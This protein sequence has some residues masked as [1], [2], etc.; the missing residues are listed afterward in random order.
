MN[1]V[2]PTGFTYRQFCDEVRRFDQVQ[3]LT[4]IARI[5]ITLPED[6]GDQRYQR[7]PPWTL[8]ALAK[9]SICHGNAYRSTQVL[10][11]DIARLCWMY[12]NINPDELGDPALNPL[13]NSLL[14]IAYEQFPYQESA[15]EELA[16]VEA[17]FAGYSGRKRLEVL[18]EAGVTELLGAPTGPAVGVAMMLH[19]S[20]MI[21]N[22]FF[23]PAWLDQKNFADVLSIL[24]REHIESV[25][26]ESFA[27]DI[28]GFRRLAESAPPLANLERY[29]FN[30]LTARPF[31]RLADGRLIAPV[32]QLIARRLSPIELYYPGIQRWNQPF[33]R[34][35]G[36]L[37]EDYVGRQLRTLPGATVYSEIK[38]GPKKE[39]KDSIDWIA[40][41]PGLVLLVEAKASRLVAA[42]R[43]GGKNAQQAV[44][45]TLNEA[46]I[47]IERTYQ[48]INDGAAGFSE[49][50]T[51]RPFVGLVATLDSAY[52]AN[53]PLARDF[54]YQARLPTL[55][56][57]VRELE[58]LVAV[59]QRLPASEVL[60]QIT[61]DPEMRTS[62]LGSALQ[63]FQDDKYDNPILDAAFDSYPFSDPTRADNTAT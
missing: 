27:T 18:D 45:E 44:A 36:E 1:T 50:P 39:K 29:M 35:L 9:A 8:A 58:S 7:T 55:I 34:D 5:A 26:N 61:D 40:V 48:A 42:A 3:M 56:G 43:A 38:Y 10:P 17:F 16:R 28:A 57:S 63:R 62:M 21:N 4:G 14:R 46:L 30:P 54:L 49:I 2:E 22:G 37:F 32:P 33:T 13:F 59:G 52:M 41:F 25:V 53:T 19:A 23:D 51:D 15:Y 31:L 20:A 12:Q 60:K 6:P 47:Q 11:T 24:P